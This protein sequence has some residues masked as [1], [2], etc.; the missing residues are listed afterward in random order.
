MHVMNN[1][2]FIA[3]LS[4]HAIRYGIA[5]V[6]VLLQ[7]FLLVTEQKSNTLKYIYLFILIHFMHQNIQNIGICAY[8]DVCDLKII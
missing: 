4:Y 8:L 1:V 7:V 6:V 5:I 2:V 3:L